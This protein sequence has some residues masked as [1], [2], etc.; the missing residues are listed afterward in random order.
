MTKVID[1][2]DIKTLGLSQVIRMYVC[3][4]TPLA[5]D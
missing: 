1:T 5:Y 2:S 3:M 4:L